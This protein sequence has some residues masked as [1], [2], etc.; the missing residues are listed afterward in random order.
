MASKS[1]RQRGNHTEHA[2]R[3]TAAQRTPPSLRTRHALWVRAS[4]LPGDL[5]EVLYATVRRWLAERW[6][7]AGV[8]W[9]GRELPWD[10]YDA[11]P[12]R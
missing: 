4:E 7:F 10:E 11:L 9:P 6:P 8:V 1:R 3:E 2:S 5:D 12:D